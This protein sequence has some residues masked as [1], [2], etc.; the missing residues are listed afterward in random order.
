MKSK[1]YILNLVTLFLFISFVSCKDNKSGYSCVDD[2]CVADFDNPQYLTLEDCQNVCNCSINGSGYSC[3]D[4]QC[5]AVS[6][7][8]NYA[9]LELCENNCADTRDGRV[10][11]NV[12]WSPWSMHFVDV[13]IAYSSTDA[14]NNSFFKDLHFYSNNSATLSLSPDIYYYKADFTY[15]DNLLDTKSGSFTIEPNTGTTVRIDFQE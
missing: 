7:D 14:A 3:I 11:F 9:T 8:A 10:T 1:L 4:G 6:S 13:G 15:S 2:Q 5:V 12:Y